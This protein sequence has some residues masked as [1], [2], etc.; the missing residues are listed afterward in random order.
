MK[1]RAVSKIGRTPHPL[2]GASVSHP[3]W[4][5]ASFLLGLLIAS[6]PV[7]R[8]TSSCDIAIRLDALTVSS[9]ST[10]TGFPPLLPDHQNP[11]IFFRKKVDINE[12][13]NNA[14]YICHERAS[15]TVSD[16]WIYDELTGAGPT[17]LAWSG[18][19]TYHAETNGQTTIDCS[20][21]RI[22]PNQ[23]SDP[24]CE[25]VHP[26]P[27]DVAVSNR[28]MSA[29]SLTLTRDEYELITT[30]EG[31][32]V[33]QVSESSSR[34]I[35]L[36]HPYALS[37]FLNNVS[38]ALQA[39]PWPDWTNATRNASA[40]RGGRNVINYVSEDRAEFSAAL[41]KLKYRIA[42]RGPQNQKHTIAWI[43]RF[44]PNGGG[45]VLDSQFT[46][47][48][49]FTGQEQ[50]LLATGAEQGKILQPP[51][52]T[53]KIEVLLMTAAACDGQTCQPGKGK[54]S[55]G[56]IEVTISLG[57]T[58][59]GESAG[60][61]SIQEERPAP[62]L[63]NPARLHYFVNH[64]VEVIK[65]GAV[66]RQIKAPQTLAQIV[67]DLSGYDI[68]FYAEATNKD[69]NGYYLP[70]G[71]P[72]LT[73][74]IE[75]PGLDPNRLRVIQTGAGE[76][77]LSDFQWSAIDQAWALLTGEVRK[78]IRS[79]SQANGFR[80]ETFAIKELDDRVAYQ[81]LH[82]WK[83]YGGLLGDRLVYEEIGSQD[84]PLV[85]SWLYYDDPLNRSSYGKVRSITRTLGGEESY[86]YDSSGRLN[87]IRSTFVY[88]PGGRVIQYSYVPVDPLDDGT[89]ES[90]SP[91][92]TIEQLLGHEIR[93]DYRSVRPNETLEI[94]CQTA[95]AAW[96]DPNNL[97]TTNRA[98][99]VPG[100]DGTIEST[101]YPDG[102]LRMTR[103]PTVQPGVPRI[104]SVAV[105]QPDATGADIADGT[106]TSTKFDGAGRLASRDILDIRSDTVLSSEVYDYPD[107]FSPA[108][109]VTYLDATSVTTLYDCC[110]V[111][112][113]IDRDGAVTSYT[114]DELGRLASSTRNGIT[115]F[116]AYDAADNLILT[117]RQGT[118]G[119]VMLVNQA[120]YDSAG[121]QISSTDAL[122][123]TT[124]TFS[125]TLPGEVDNL[126]ITTMPDG[127]FRTEI[128]ATD[129]SLME[130][131][132]SASNPSR[133]EYGV[134]EDDGEYRFFTKEIKRTDS[135]TDSSEWTKTY[136]DMLGRPCK[137]LYADGTYR[138]S[139]YDRS[140]KLCK[141]R[142]PD[143]RI[144][145]YAYNARGELEFTALD[146]DQSDSIDLDG[147]DRVTRKVTDIASGRVRTR[148]F[149]WPTIGAADSLLVST[150]EVS[151]DG[152]LS[153][154]SRF[155]LD[156]TTRAEYLGS[157][158]R[159]VTEF[160]SDGSRTV[161][162][163]HSGLLLS[164]IRTGAN[165]EELGAATCHYDAHGRLIAVTDSRTGTATSY[166][167]NDADLVTRIITPAW[168]GL[169]SAATTIAYDDLGRMIGVTSPDGGNVTN[170][171]TP[172]GQ[173]RKTFGARTYPVEYSYD[174]QGRLTNLTTWSALGSASTRWS[175]DEQRGWLKRKWY[176]DDTGPTYSYTPS[177][178]LESRASAR[179]LATSYTYNE[180]GDLQSLDYEDPARNVEFLDFDRLGHP[181]QVRIGTNAIRLA[182]HE[183]GPLIS[184][185]FGPLTVTNALDASLRP[186]SVILR[187]R[188]STTALLQYSFAYDGASRL[189][190]VNAGP[191]SV[192][193]RYLPKSTLIQDITFRFHGRLLM[194]TTRTHDPLNRLTSI[195]SAPAGA[196]A[197]VFAYRYNLASQLSY[198]SEADGSHWLY[199][200][201]PLGQLT[202]GRKF[203]NDG[204]PVAGQ[205][206]DYFFD[207]IGNRSVT[208]SGGDSTGAG[209]RPASYTPNLLNQY[210][211]REVVGVVDILGQAPAQATVTVN[212]LSP[213][214]KNNYFQLALPFHNTAAAAYPTVT[215]QAV[216][217]NNSR[218][219]A[220]HLFLARTPESFTYDQ[221]GNRI[222]DGRW[223]LTWD[224]ENRLVELETRPDIP[225]D[226]RKKL[227]FNYDHRGR[228]INKTV[229]N[230][231]ARTGSY[232]SARQTR[233][234]YDDW[235]LLAELDETN[236]LLRSYVWG[237]DLSGT[238]EGAGGIG[239][240]L[241]MVDHR[242][243]G[244]AYFYACDGLGHV[245][246]LINATTGADAAQYDYGPFGELL[247]A[248]GP[249]ARE[250]PFRF[251]TK[252]QDDETD[253]VYFGHRWY[254]PG[255]GC[256]LSRDPAEESGGAN[257]YAFVRNDPLNAI[258]PLGRE[259]FT[260]ITVKRKRVQWLALLRSKLGKKPSPDD[261]YG[262]WWLEFDGESYGW[263][264]KNGVTLIESLTSVPGRLN[265]TDDMHADGLASETRDGHHGDSGDEEFHPRRRMGLLGGAKLQHGSAVGTNCK[266]VTEDETKD[267]VRT[268]ARQ[269]HGRWSYPWGQNCHSFQA[270]ALRSC[271]LTK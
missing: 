72:N 227:T 117:R 255:T 64:D 218:T 235:R 28:T 50:F 22:G 214:R 190:T 56:S 207:S 63:T 196:P 12:S 104:Q 74:R 126:E 266:C 208:R 16:T 134:D 61:L 100:F 195:A 125:G 254:E 137:T 43:E 193:Y 45:P 200:Y 230:W 212:N 159:R 83:Q 163:Y 257:L 253:F 116:Y 10:R 123:N 223:T 121:R 217:L 204:T 174:P 105:G 17:L 268:F 249:M 260:S 40:E 6:A 158:V 91:R 246:A 171:Y 32:A 192:L 49:T 248:T 263:W 59:S 219:E 184:E 114:R 148:T 8:A 179:G 205:Q 186:Q 92:T 233:F 118:N 172:A 242:H 111:I 135:E 261:P 238:L 142:D 245:R 2:P 151:P 194:I 109:R 215:N 136:L 161:S 244:V 170:Q 160:I 65:D 41:S 173:L 18:S 131:Y 176:A 240:L 203:W 90:D 122:G 168:T 67:P 82:T 14:C 154:E 51:D 213:Y 166:Q 156:T 180:A 55:T 70:I 145:L 133:Y 101:V 87:T 69:V 201:D 202:R 115:L 46:E 77:L 164:V 19:K 206:F 48:V 42:V 224:A 247:R 140:G 169:P 155:G 264:P 36:S 243:G 60:S 37:D 13:V 191:V 35:N 75:S 147:A 128:Y 7:A 259:E 150:R 175:H 15:Y 58:P 102:T 29:Y 11:T 262:H 76:P 178:Q 162:Y 216:L 209:L 88:T 237:A 54:V 167:Y 231:N 66:L 258:D 226:A 52:R 81:E 153:L 141:Q 241:A 26:S 250:N 110:N 229:L 143:G 53:G 86:E 9:N 198:A 24:D 132:G 187:A 3:A 99:A 197:S 85:T 177:G 269:Y 21:S 103:R 4:R 188:E 165:G 84:N 33:Y 138:Q 183:A 211:S 23:W 265:G 78:E 89:R 182:Y 95:G 108:S 25:P 38:A 47:E 225:D 127:S 239:G 236:G 129:G 189:Q 149:V 93:R 44:T 144:T 39:A 94:K 251:S 34:D 222:N 130:V 79:S 107:P 139:F 71:Q 270:S 271:C 73:W 20:S 146:V 5:F 181:A 124:L 221:D 96:N 112:A 185:T 157:G 98:Y 234:I 119:T 220:G 62:D 228:R 113:T 68:R 252:Y 1:I 31:S 210:I 30:S 80:T 120:T 256:W 57:K 232:D 199:D 267:C 106:R 27:S 97:I 152:R